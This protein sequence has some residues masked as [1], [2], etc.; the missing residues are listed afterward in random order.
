MSH[1]WSGW[2][3]AYCLK[4]GTS[5]P[6]E[7]ALVCNECIIPLPGEGN[8]PPQEMKLCSLHQLWHSAPCP[9]PQETV[10]EINQLMLKS[11]NPYFHNAQEKQTCP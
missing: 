10:Q 3:G 11:G 6:L 4:C 9:I 8:L 2:P 1:Q 5:D 7:E